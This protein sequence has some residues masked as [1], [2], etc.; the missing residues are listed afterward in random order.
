MKTVPIQTAQG[1]YQVIIERGL[2]A[3][4]GVLIRESFGSPRILIFADSTVD[5]LYGDAVQ[6]SLNSAGIDS[7]R[8][9]FPAGEAS[10]TLNTTRPFA[11]L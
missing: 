4:I 11:F 7:P 3:R 10:K 5:R 8:F 2:T 6:A 9:V 1:D